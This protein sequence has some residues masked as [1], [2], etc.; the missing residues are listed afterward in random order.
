MNDLYKQD[1]LIVINLP[2]KFVINRKV[3]EII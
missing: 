1:R 2:F 3:N